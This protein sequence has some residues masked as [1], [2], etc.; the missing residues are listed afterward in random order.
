MAGRLSGAG[1]A[2][3]AATFRRFGL[4]KLWRGGKRR[5][6]GEKEKEEWVVQ[7]ERE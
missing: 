6:E 5:K 2:H 3:M 7:E 4:A 1:E